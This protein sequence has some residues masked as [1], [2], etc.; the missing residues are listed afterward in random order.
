VEINNGHIYFDSMDHKG[1]FRVGNIL[2]VNQQTGQVTFDAQSIN[3]GAS[4][5]ITLDGPGSQT[6]IDATKVQVGNIRIYDNNIDSLLGPVNFHAFSGIT[7]LNTDVFVTGN[8][9][10]S[11]LMYL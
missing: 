7:T 11:K 4:G 6:I 1:N 9:N 10:V 8:V 5:N 2:L 3:F